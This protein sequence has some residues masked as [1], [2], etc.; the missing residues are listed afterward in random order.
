MLSCVGAFLCIVT[1]IF[2]NFVRLVHYVGFAIVNLI[3]NALY[4]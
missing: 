1:D 4:T 2:F 3:E